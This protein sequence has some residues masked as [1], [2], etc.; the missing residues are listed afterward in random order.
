MPSITVVGSIN[1]DLVVRTPRVP[2]R[3]ETISGTDFR[4]F[5]GGKGANQAVAAQRQGGTV[6]MIGCVGDDPFGQQMLSGLGSEGI[7]TSLVT[8]VPGTPSGVAL[9]SVEQSGENRII[10]V[11]GANG[12]VSPAIVEAAQGAFASKVLLMQLEIPLSAVL[13]AANLARRKGMQ[14]ILNAA[15]AR[16][17]PPELISLVD[18]LVV[19]EIEAASLSGLD[20][21]KPEECAEALREAGARNV[22]VTLGAE[23]AI[24]HGEG[25]TVRVA[26]YRVQVVDTT[27]AGDAFVG[28]FAVGL[29]EG[30]SAEEAVARGN[31]AGALAVT[32]MGA[33]PSLPTR[34][35]TDDYLSKQIQDVQK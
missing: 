16:P 8:V 15:P 30:A 22:V 4:T 12:L 28:A 7:D 24:L 2:E 1:M 31:C 18:Y 26:S 5:P 29:T 9:I 25:G 11:A 19:N 6:A 23:G 20:P 3:G 33:Q 10:I 34:D 14:V 27:A 17:L 21:S 32:R 35:A 13:S